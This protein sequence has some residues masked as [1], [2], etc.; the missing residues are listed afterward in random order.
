MVITRSN[1]I[2]ISPGDCLG[3]FKKSVL[4][5]SLPVFVCLASCW[6]NVGH[7][8]TSNI[9]TGGGLPLLLLLGPAARSSSS[10]RAYWNAIVALWLLQLLWLVVDAV[11][12][13]PTVAVAIPTVVGVAVGPT[14]ELL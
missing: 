1:E 7:V 12:I 6:L 4:V 8:S 14:V 2:Y 11:A 3:G 9:T 13:G 5:P 10:S